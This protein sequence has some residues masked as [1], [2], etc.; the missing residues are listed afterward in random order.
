[1]VFIFVPSKKTPNYD[2]SIINGVFENYW[3]FERKQVF[4]VSQNLQDLTKEYSTIE[5]LEAIQNYILS[6][7]KTNNRQI[8]LIKDIETIETAKKQAILGIKPVSIFDDLC[9]KLIK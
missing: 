4:D 9:L 5:I 6:A 7:L 3:E 1:L 8:Q 2:Y